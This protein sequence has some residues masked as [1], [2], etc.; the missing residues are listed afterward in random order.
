MTCMY[1]Y[2]VQVE[3]YREESGV[4]RDRQVDYVKGNK[5]RKYMEILDRDIWRLNM[6]VSEE[7]I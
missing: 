2:V 4:G 7:R 6:I 1:D 3:I 5:G